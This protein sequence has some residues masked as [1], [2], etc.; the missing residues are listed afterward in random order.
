MTDPKRRG[1]P[2]KVSRET[3]TSRQDEAHTPKRPERVPMGQGIRLRLPADF[4]TDNFMPRFCL[5]DKRGKIEIYLAAYWEFYTDSDGSQLRHPAGSGQEMVLMKLPVKYHEEDMKLQ[6]KR[7][8]GTLA[9]EVGP[10]KDDEY[11]P[12]G[13]AS[14]VGVGV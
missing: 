7:N 2:R 6:E 12:E 1:R 9:K 11:I 8:I 10:V 4:D 14:V 3:S 13:H 5:D